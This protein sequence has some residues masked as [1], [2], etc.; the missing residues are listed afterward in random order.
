MTPLTGIEV[1]QDSS[2]EK[3]PVFRALLKGLVS[4]CPDCGLGPMFA[5]YLRVADSCSHCGTELHHHRADDAPPYFTMM[6]VGHVVIGLVLFAEMVY[7]PPIWLHMT[8]WL[9]LT[10]ILSLA[11]MRPVKGIIVALQWALQM[12]GFGGAE[13]EVDAPPGEVQ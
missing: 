1:A 13:D 6:I 8:L 3:R 11:L 2:A 12:H 10:L 7:S 4:R 5:G 9:P